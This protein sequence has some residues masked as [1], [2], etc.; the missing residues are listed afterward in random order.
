MLV[1]KSRGLVRQVV[2]DW[3]K[4]FEGQEFLIGSTTYC[5]TP[6]DATHARRLVAKE[7]KN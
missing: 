1:F 7:E 6:S 4:E 3:L 5:I 2:E